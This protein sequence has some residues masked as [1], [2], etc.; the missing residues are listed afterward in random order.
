M[1]PLVRCSSVYLSGLVIEFEFFLVAH[2]IYGVPQ[3]INTANYV[4]FQAFREI[5]MLQGQTSK[6]VKDVM[7]DIIVGEDKFSFSVV[8]T[9][10]QLDAIT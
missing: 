5:S 4:Y 1:E 8:C 2:K 6:A 10:T 7:Y 9:L 3:T